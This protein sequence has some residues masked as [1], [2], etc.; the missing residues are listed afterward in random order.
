MYIRQK[1]HFPFPLF[2]LVWKRVRFQL[3]TGMPTLTSA[4]DHPVKLSEV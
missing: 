3:H 2:H 4:Q 1:T